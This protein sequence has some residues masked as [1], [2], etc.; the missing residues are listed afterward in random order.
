MDFVQSSTAVGGSLALTAL[1]GI[2]PLLTFFVMLGVLRMKSHFAALGS[3]AVSLI[4]AVVAYGMPAQYAVLSASEGVVAGLFPILWIVMMAVWFYHITEESGRTKDLRELF[5]I[6]GRGDIRIQAVL[7]AFC[8]GAILEALAGFGAPVAIVCALLIALGLK[9][10]KAA[11]VTLIANTAPV[12]FGAMGTPVTTAGQLL[13]S[14]NGPAMA[15][16]V[17]MDVVIMIP[18][19]AAFVPLMLVA[20]LDG[21]RGVKQL[22]PFA[23]AVGIFFALAQHFSVPVVGYELT[24]VTSAAG[25][26]V[27]AIL[28]FIFWKPTTPEEYKTETGTD[29]TAM[30]GWMAVMPYVLV[31]LI[32]G[33]SNLIPAIKKF[34]GQFTQKVAWPLIDGHIFAEGASKASSTTVL[35]IPWLANP[36]TLLFITAV[37]VVVAYTLCNEN[38]RYELGFGKSV[39][40]FFQTFYDNRYAILTIATILGL[41]YVMNAS[42]QT[43]AVGAFLAGA[44]KIFVCFSPILGWIGTAVTGSDTS[45]NA[46]FTTL[47]STAAKKIGVEPTWTVAANTCG[48]VIGKVVSPQNLAIAATSIGMPGSESTLFRKVVAFSVGMLIAICVLCAVFSGV[49]F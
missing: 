23:L 3:L 39:K 36:G 28:L 19:I 34:L 40:L 33:A 4:I 37:I 20:L 46:L 31:I 17:A 7:I 16:A 10:L 2:L 49:F 24:D 38:G 44:G 35:S 42:G 14:A 29:L 5:S 41:A 6:L 45:A 8:F 47:Q 11:V 12:A 48:G 15:H 13:D 27:G 43:V 26:F 21:K 9:P 25:G 18:F 32:F 1:L 22:W 30:R